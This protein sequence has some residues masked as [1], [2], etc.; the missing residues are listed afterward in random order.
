M[1]NLDMPVELVGSFDYGNG[2]SGT[3]IVVQHRVGIRDSTGE[4]WYF[5]W[6]ERCPF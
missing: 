3:V 5:Q 2:V 4:S 6:D 1:W